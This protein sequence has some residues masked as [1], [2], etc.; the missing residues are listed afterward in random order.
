MPSGTC[1]DSE[2]LPEPI[3]VGDAEDFVGQNA[4]WVVRQREAEVQRA[5]VPRHHL[6]ESGRRGAGPEEAR[7]VHT[8]GR[9]HAEMA[10]GALAERP[11]PLGNAPDVDAVGST[12]I[13]T[14]LGWVPSG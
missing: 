1:S 3:Q 8:R 11:P 7:C 12:P 14:L 5:D 9:D 2:A 4:V 13:T 10:V 6:A